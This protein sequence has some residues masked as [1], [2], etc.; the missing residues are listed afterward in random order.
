MCLLHKR[1]YAYVY[2]N[3]LSA[4]CWTVLLILLSESNVSCSNLRPSI[5]SRLMNSTTAALINPPSGA[6]IQLF[7]VFFICRQSDMW[8]TESHRVLIIIDA[9]S[10]RVRSKCAS[11][12]RCRVCL[13]T[14]TRDRIGRSWL[15]DQVPLG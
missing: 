6:Y 9:E 12:F 3:Y 11:L 2:M 13:S 10:R 7:R 8:A 1:L 4:L 5:I 15:I 14:V